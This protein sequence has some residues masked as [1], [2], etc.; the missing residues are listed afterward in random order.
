MRIPWGTLQ[1][2][3]RSLPEHGTVLCGEAAE[4][5]ETVSSGG[6]RDIGRRRIRVTQCRPHHPQAPQ[7]QISDGAHAQ[8]FCA[9]R[10]QGPLGHPDGPAQVWQVRDA[11]GMRR[12]RLFELAHYLGPAAP[13]RQIPAVSPDAQAGD[14]RADQLLFERAGDLRVRKQRGLLLDKATGIRMQPSKAGYGRRRQPQ[15]PPSRRRQKLFPGQG[16]AACCEVLEGL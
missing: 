16:L 14:E 5:Q 10:T 12:E 11:L 13:G 1:R 8:E 4:L 15:H 3:R 7:A 6:V 9:A 2:G